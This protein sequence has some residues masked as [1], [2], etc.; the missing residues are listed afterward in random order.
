[1]IN[2]KQTLI[3]LVCSIGI[4]SKKIGSW[5]IMFTDMLKY[6]DSVFDFI[7]S[8]KPDFLIENVVNESVSD[9]SF[10]DKLKAK[11]NKYYLKYNYWKKIRE[12]LSESNQLVINIIDDFNMVNSIHYFATKEGV[13]DRVKINF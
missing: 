2:E 8:P 12:K 4:P 5:N 13:R 10:I 7:I 3:V 1:M 11:K 6:D 9:L